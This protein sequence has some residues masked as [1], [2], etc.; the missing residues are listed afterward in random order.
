[1]ALSLNFQFN[2]TCVLLIQGGPH[3]ITI[4]ETVAIQLSFEILGFNIRRL[5]AKVGKFFMETSL[6]LR[7]IT[8]VCKFTLRLWLMK[9]NCVKLG[10][11]FNMRRFV[12]CRG[13]V[14][15]KIKDFR[16]HGA[17]SV[18]ISTLLRV[19]ILQISMNF[20]VDS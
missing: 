5:I 7:L 20:E 6:Q 10:S 18:H 17:H 15:Q 9:T 13:I 4:L 16:L 11:L 1:M 3:Q 19:Q 8:T 2:F 12:C 14:L